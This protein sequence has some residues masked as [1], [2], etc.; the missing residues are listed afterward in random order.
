MIAHRIGMIPIL[1]DVTTFEPGLY[2][3]VIDKEN[4]TKTMM[5]VCASDI[6]VF[7][8]N[9]D[10]PLE[11][12]VRIPTEEFFPPD[13]ITGDTCLITRLRPQ[14]NPSSPNERIVLK[15]RASISTGEENIRWSP[16]SQ[17]SYE[18]TRDENPDNIEET[19]VNW[20]KNNKKITDVATLPAERKEELKREFNTMEIQRCYLKNDKGEPNDFTFFVESIGTQPIAQIVHAGIVSCIS[21]VNTYATVDS[22]LP[23][24]VTLLPG[25]ARFPC[26]DVYFKNENHTLG[27]LLETFIIENHVDG[28]AEPRITYAGY[29]VPHPL[30]PEMFVRIGILSDDPEVRIQTTRLVIANACRDL[31]EY[32]HKLERSWK[33]ISGLAV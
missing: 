12:P 33:D 10:A 23:S 19:F 16:V 26:Y 22:A 24:N 9:P 6:Q 11:A 13:P 32:F 2:E 7:K 14:W 17:C 15:A 25:D 27:N 3:F 21:K 8:K 1:A 18:Y 20:L 29:K 4:N 30:R 5:D 31:K 28:S